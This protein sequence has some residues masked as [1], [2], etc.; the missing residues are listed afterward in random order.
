VHSVLP[1]V[2]RG[3]AVVNGESGPERCQEPLNFAG[4]VDISN[5]EQPRLLSIFPNP[6]PSPGLDFSNYCD[7]GGRFGPHNS[8]LPQNNPHTLHRD[9]LVYLTWF[10]ARLRIYDIGDPRQPTEAGCFVPPD[11]RE[12][13][14]LF[15]TTA[16]VTQTEDVLVDARGSIYITG[17]NHG[18]FIL[19]YMG[20]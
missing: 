13:I 7:K 1:L 18:I 11:P 3:I 12:R 17:K 5:E 6:R 10:N 2:D 20:N 19:E 14:G 15:P 9:D 4:I 8:H 16:L